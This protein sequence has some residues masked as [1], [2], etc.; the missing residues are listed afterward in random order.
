[1]LGQELHQRRD[2]V[3]AERIVAEIDGVQVRQ[4]EQGGEERGEG[5]GDL[6]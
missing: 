5:G 6:G 4:G 1:M 2:G 3:E